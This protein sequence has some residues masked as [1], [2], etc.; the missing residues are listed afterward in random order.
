MYE[1]ITSSN[2]NFIKE[3]KKLRQKKYRQKLNKFII[4]SKKLILE[5]ISSGY[6]IENIFVVEGKSSLFD[7]EIYVSE[8]LFDAIT[9][10]VNPDGYLAIV[11]IKKNKLLT[12]K[13][14]ILDNIQDP[15]N[16]GTLIRSA[17][18]FG[19]NTI[20]SINSVDFY[21]E[22][23]LRATM[24]SGFR[25]NLID[26]NYKFLEN[27]KDYTIYIADMD[28]YD[29][30]KSIPSKKIAIVIGNEGNGISDNILSFNHELIK[31]PMLGKIESL[32]AGVS[33]SILMS[34]FIEV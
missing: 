19:F 15:G 29:Y 7:D 30:R 22:K 18:A 12:D 3:I 17:E 16:M 13:V 9:S 5:A 20:V 8:K 10:M 24:G 32:N 33:G 2:S 21:N 34:N 25:L 1:K 11:K 6:E 4:E 23:V 14:L 26:T 28:G 27:M 31:I